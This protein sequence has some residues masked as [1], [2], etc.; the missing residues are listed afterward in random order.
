MSTWRELSVCATKVATYGIACG[1]TVMTVTTGGGRCAAGSSLEQ[2]ATSNA[3]KPTIT[4]RITS[5]PPLFRTSGIV[6]WI[7]GPSR[8]GGTQQRARLRPRLELEPDVETILIGED[9][10]D[11]AGAVDPL[12]DGDGSQEDI[13]IHF[14]A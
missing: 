2:P 11:R 5:V 8:Y 13:P 1:F 14:P 3:Q 7:Q 12:P 4:A 10:A 9:R 6:A